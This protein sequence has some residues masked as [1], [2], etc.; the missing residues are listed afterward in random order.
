M[1]LPRQVEAQLRELE[2]LEKQLAEGTVPRLLLSTNHL[3][4]KLEKEKAA[5]YRQRQ[6]NQGVTE[7]DGSLYGA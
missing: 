4:I 7:G 6:K 1:A 2:A 5:E 3:P